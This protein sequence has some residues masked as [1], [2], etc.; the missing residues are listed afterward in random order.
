MFERV[1]ASIPHPV[2]LT[3]SVTWCQASA[4]SNRIFPP[5]RNNGVVGS[6]PS[7]PRILSLTEAH[8]CTTADGEL[9]E[10]AVLRRIKSCPLTVGREDGTSTF[11]TANGHRLR[12][13]HGAEVELLV[14]TVHEPVPSGERATTRRPVIGSETSGRKVSENRATDRRWRIGAHYT[15]HRDTGDDADQQTG[16][17]RQA[18]GFT[19]KSIHLDRFLA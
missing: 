2:S 4:V 15:P 5:S 16:S 11:R 7:T 1:S 19:R 12:L 17:A 6:P 9:L 8:G 10:S 3:V 18:F 14:G 13:V